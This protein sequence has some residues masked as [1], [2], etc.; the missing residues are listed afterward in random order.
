[1][2]LM[3]NCVFFLFI[4]LYLGSY[5]HALLC[6]LT[7]Q[8]LIL[9]LYVNWNMEAL[10]DLSN[11]FLT[12]SSQGLPVMFNITRLPL[13]LKHFYMALILLFIFREI[14]YKTVSDI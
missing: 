14:L 8:L 9:Y 10:A 3:G 7:A 11:P 5:L 13:E 4:F 1:M 12:Q 2:F 6:H